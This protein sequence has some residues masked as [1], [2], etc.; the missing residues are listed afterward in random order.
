M[1][2]S[3]NIDPIQFSENSVEYLDL[4]YV[5]LSI[6]MKKRAHFEIQDRINRIGIAMIAFIVISLLM[7]Y[8]PLNKSI[9]VL[10][11]D[12]VGFANVLA[13][14]KVDIAE[15]ADLI[16]KNIAASSQ[17]VASRIE[18]SVHELKPTQIP[19]LDDLQDKKPAL[20]VKEVIK[21]LKRE[22]PREDSNWQKHVKIQLS[23]GAVQ[24]LAELKKRYPIYFGW[25][26]D[27]DVIYSTTVSIRFKHSGYFKGKFLPLSERGYVVYMYDGYKAN[28]ADGEFLNVMRL[29]ASFQFH[30]KAGS[31]KTYTV[32]SSKPLTSSLGR[33][34]T[35][36][37]VTSN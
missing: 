24:N 34:L 30:G 2:N 32:Y 1:Y 5:C 25:L 27:T 9:R 7:A 16:F 13:S 11:E 36:S 23:K 18:T 31:T 15:S 19:D 17:E 35:A 12:G 14:G 20:E 22:R 8:E 37:F 6:F 21:D 26:A 3:R 4:F 29:P 10:L 28:Y 33:Y